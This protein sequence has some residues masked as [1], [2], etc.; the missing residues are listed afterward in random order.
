MRRLKQ[1]EP[2]EQE[3]RDYV[4]RSTLDRAWRLAQQGNR[5]VDDLLGRALFAASD[6]MVKVVEEQ[7]LEV[8]VSPAGFS[9]RQKVTVPA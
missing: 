1:R 4:I 8:Q 9:W 7:G 3:K 6:A 2:T 5:A